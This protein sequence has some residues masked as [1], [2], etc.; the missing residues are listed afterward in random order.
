MKGEEIAGLFR[1]DRCT[2]YHVALVL[3]AYFVSHLHPLTD[4]NDRFAIGTSRHRAVALSITGCT[5]H[6]LGLGYRQGRG[7]AQES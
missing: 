7:E 2:I 3:T 6:C 1:Y 5:D 4:D